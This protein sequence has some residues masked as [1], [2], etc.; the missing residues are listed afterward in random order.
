MLISF[1][2]FTVYLCANSYIA[3]SGISQKKFNLLSTAVN[4]LVEIQ[5]F[6]HQVLIVL[7]VKDCVVFGPWTLECRCLL[8][9]LTDGVCAFNKTNVG[10]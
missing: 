4:L 8:V 3:L 10:S 5:T 7:I 2:W 9:H 1:Y 6:I